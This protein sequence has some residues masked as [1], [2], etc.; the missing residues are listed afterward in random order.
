MLSKRGPGY[1]GTFATDGAKEITFSGAYV[2]QDIYV[3]NLLKT[4]CI[5][6]S[7]ILRKY[8]RIHVNTRFFIERDASN[9]SVYHIRCINYT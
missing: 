8:A 3:T 7:C 9:P 5:Q 4:P 2:S 6:V 1:G